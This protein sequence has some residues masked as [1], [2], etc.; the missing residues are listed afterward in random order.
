MQLTILLTGGELINSLDGFIFI[1]N[2]YQNLWF[3]VTLE[4]L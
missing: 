1:Q 4:Y 2:N 3:Y